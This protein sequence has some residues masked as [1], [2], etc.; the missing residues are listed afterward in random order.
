M[1]ILFLAPH[2]FY[3]DRGTPIADLQM[4]KALSE[5]ENTF[6]DC[7]VF[8]IGS[9]IKLPKINIHRIPKINQRINLNK[10]NLRFFLFL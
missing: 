5:K 4:L 8:H 1:R 6:V 7:L 2:P 3:K 10:Y 9:D